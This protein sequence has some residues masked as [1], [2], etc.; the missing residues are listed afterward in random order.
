MRAGS[1]LAEPPISQ[2]WLGVDQL[3]SELD[4]A[5]VVSLRALTARLGV[6]LN[7][8]AFIERTET[9]R[10]NRAVVHEHVSAATVDLNEA[11]ALFA[12]E[13]F[14]SSFVYDIS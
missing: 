12:V 1:Q 8:L 3:L 5:Y 2:L 6:E 13:P 7:A 9:R 10:L 4:R 11:E 14:D